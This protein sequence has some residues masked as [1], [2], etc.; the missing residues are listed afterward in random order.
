MRRL[1]GDGALV[2]AF[3]LSRPAGRAE[4]AVADC[5]TGL[6]CVDRIYSDVAVIDVTRQGLVV[7]DMVPGL[8]AA[9][10]QALTG[11]PLGFADTCRLLLTAEAA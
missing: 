1:H 3:P 10:L 8:S 5:T 7:T 6:A 9:E 11:A 2:A 4:G